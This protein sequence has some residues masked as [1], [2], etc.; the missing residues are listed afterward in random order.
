MRERGRLLR[1]SNTSHTHQGSKILA[2]VEERK[3]RQEP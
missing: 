1:E 2:S 3:E